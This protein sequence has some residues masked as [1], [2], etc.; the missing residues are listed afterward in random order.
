M[1]S[2]WFVLK[3]N[4]TNFNR[5]LSISK[6]E[7][8]ADYRE[9]R[10]GVLW[11]VF[12]PLIQIFTYWIAFG[13]IMRKGSPATSP[14]GV[15][16]SYLPWMVVGIAVWFFVSPCITKG[17]N[18]IYAKRNIITKMKFPISI[19]PATVVFKELFNH[20]VMIGVV[21]LLLLVRGHEPNLLWLQVLYYMFCAVCLCIALGMVTSV[22]NMFTRDVK[23]LISACMRML[24]YLSPILWPITDVL[25]SS[26]SL[27]RSLEPFIKLNPLY[28][29]IEGYRGS[30]FYQ[31]PVTMHPAQT[32]YFWCVVV[33]LYVVGSILMYKFK[34]K[35]IDML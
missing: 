15:G 18:A 6:Y 7:T 14:T 25:A 5:I 22:L 3:E 21:L 17:C 34:H 16:I 19:L 11:S 4:L 33:G 13:L 1:K 26:S 20:I 2:V 28:Y 24:M 8:L 23:K 9:S 32:L 31:D 10:L 12:N 27:V 35:F 30:L 29:I